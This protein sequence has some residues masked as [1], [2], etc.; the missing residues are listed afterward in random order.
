M[1]EHIPKHIKPVPSASDRSFGFVFAIFFTI[2]ALLPLLN[3]R[4]IRFWSLGLATIFLLLALLIPVVLAPLN[5]LWGW[6]GSLLHR[7]VSPVA[8]GVLF[9]LV[10]MPTGLIMRVLGKDPL[11]MQLDPHA[12]TYW[13]ERSPPGPDADSLK[14]QF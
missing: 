7:I 13:I 12:K 9:F 14:N 3:S 10:V 1:N 8:L 2:V 11:R 6:F 4:P 5:R